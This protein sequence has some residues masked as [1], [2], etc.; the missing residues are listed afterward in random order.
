MKTGT[1]PSYT[2][3]TGKEFFEHSI[4]YKKSDVLLPNHTLSREILA[5]LH[6]I[7]FASSRLYT[8]DT[9]SLHE[10]RPSTHSLSA[11]RSAVVE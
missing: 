8:G 3:L 2:E 11:L 9:Y 1:Y 10:L 5:G 6:Q 7:T 4:H